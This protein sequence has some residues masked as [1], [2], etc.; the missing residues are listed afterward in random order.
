MVSPFVFSV[1]L[2]FKNFPITPVQCRKK[3]DQFFLFF[4]NKFSAYQLRAFFQTAKKWRFP[5]YKPV[6]LF[7]LRRRLSGRFTM[8]SRAFLRANSP[9]VPTLFAT[10]IRTRT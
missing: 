5:H 8:R 10:R 9:I 7:F 4:A 1:V 2:K 3:G 6:T